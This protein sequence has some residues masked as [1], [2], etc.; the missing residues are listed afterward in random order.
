MGPVL[1]HRVLHSEGPTL[2]LHCLQ[3]LSL[4]SY[5]FQLR[6]YVLWG[7][8]GYWP[9][10]PWRHL[11]CCFLPRKASRWVA[12]A[13]LPLSATDLGAEVGDG[14]GEAPPWHTQVGSVAVVTAQGWQFGRWSAEHCCW[15]LIHLQLPLWKLSKSWILIWKQVIWRWIEFRLIIFFAVKDEG[16]LYSQQ[17]RDRELT[18]AQIMN[19]LLPNSDLSWRK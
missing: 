7:L 2:G 18:V 3:L 12:R 11:T 13:L 14:G 1:A 8:M 9:P 16:A 15:N 17:K 10:G 4:T 6:I 19:S 5:K